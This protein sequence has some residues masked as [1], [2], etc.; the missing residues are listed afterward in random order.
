MPAEA[1][2]TVKLAEAL[3][4]A[5]DEHEMLALGSLAM[6]LLPGM[7]AR[8]VSEALGETERDPRAML[9]AAAVA[10]VTDLPD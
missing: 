5:F 2:E 7:N 4:S 10:H 6:R 1:S 8:R 9:T 3:E